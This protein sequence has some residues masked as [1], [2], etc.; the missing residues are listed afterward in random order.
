MSAHRGS[1]GTSTAAHRAG[2]ARVLPE[3]NGVR[4]AATL[5]TTQAAVTQAANGPPAKR[6]R[7]A[8]PAVES[9]QQPGMLSSPHSLTHLRILT[10]NHFQ[11]RTM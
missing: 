11:R 8:A 1:R 2:A 10:H 3:R 6:A 5:G 4:S 9:P 7:K